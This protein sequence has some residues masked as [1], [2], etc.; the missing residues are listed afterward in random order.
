MIRIIESSLNKYP[1]LKQFL[2]ESNIETQRSLCKLLKPF[3]SLESVN[4]Y[5]YFCRFYSAHE[6]CVRLDRLQH[7]TSLLAE[8]P[9]PLRDRSDLLDYASRIGK[10]EIVKLLLKQQGFINPVNNPGLSALELAAENGHEEICLLLLNLPTVKNNLT[11]DKNFAFCAAARNGHINIVK[12]LLTFPQ[13]AE[14]ISID[15]QFA[16][17]WAFSNEHHDVVNLLLEYPQVFSYAEDKHLQ[18]G[19]NYLQSFV[20]HWNSLMLQKK[21]NQTVTPIELSESETRRGLLMLHFLIRS[22]KSYHASL[23]LDL[24]G[25]PSIRERVHLPLTK[26]RSNELLELSRAVN[27]HATTAMLLTIPAVYRLANLTHNQPAEL[28]K[29]SS[30]RSLNGQEE[31]LLEHLS[32]HYQE[33]IKTRGGV[34]YVFK[35]FQHYLEATYDKKPAVIVINNKPIILPREWAG[36]INLLKE[37]EFRAH[38]QEILSTYY[39]HPYHTVWRFFQKPNPW[40]APDASFVR[41]LPNNGGR[42]A[43]YE[44]YIPFIA[45]LWVAASDTKTPAIDKFSVANRVKLFIKSLALA[46]R[47]HNWDETRL[48]INGL[49]EEFDDFMQGDKPSCPPGLRRRGWESV[50]AHPL[51]NLLTPERIKTEF[52]EFVR[53]Y[54]QQ[55]LSTI[56]RPD[57]INAVDNYFANPNDRV[58]DILLSLNIPQTVQQQFIKTMQQ[59]YMVQTKQEP[60]M[61]ANL[62]ML[63]KL[64]PGEAHFITL[65]NQTYL[66]SLLKRSNRFFPSDKASSDTSTSQ[67]THAP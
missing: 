38:K 1:E 17:R 10:I 20:A 40:M 42:Y 65:F 2:D 28:S 27:N 55:Q 49:E 41:S 29:E 9:V 50:L 5:R 59:K 24:I 19:P 7:L 3:Y 36:L 56:N 44:S 32:A 16:L 54:Y 67:T 62:H 8:N 37:D 61:L 13:V 48:D 63:F 4:N 64:A 15:N 22:N 33:E 47:A 53:S 57:L 43:D 26:T 46:A 39:K 35:S 45:L 34:E 25:I 12:H 51:F 31:Y 23:I 14:N 21:Q 60:N 6:I 58:P 66:G 52:R 11:K 18:T 30:M